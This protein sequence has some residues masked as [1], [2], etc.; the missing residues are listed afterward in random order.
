ME[1]TTNPY[2]VEKTVLVEETIKVEKNAIVMDWSKVP[3]GTYM[4]ACI[5]G[6]DAEG[7]VYNDPD[8]NDVKYF[9]Q[10]VID[11]A[12]SPDKFGFKYS[13]QFSQNE[14]GTHTAGMSNFNFPPKPDNFPPKLIEVGDGSYE[15]KIISSKMIKV[16]CQVITKEQILNVL[17]EMEKFSK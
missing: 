6:D 15:C 8:S 13:W 5:H 12:D 1:N 9:C 14:D 2:L 3:N 7:F 4:T 10:N 17:E 11:G 16:G